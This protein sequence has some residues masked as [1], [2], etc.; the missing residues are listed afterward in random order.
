MKKQKFRFPVKLVLTAAIFL[1]L[2]IF[3]LFFLWSV[4]ASMSYFKVKDV[5]MIS[6]GR[7]TELSYL[8]GRNIWSLDLEREARSLSAANPN[9]KKVKLIRVLPNRVL[10][11][12][13]KR[14]PVAYLELS[15]YFCLDSGRVIF[16]SA[17]PLDLPVITG[18]RS[19]LVN[20]EPGV[21]YNSRELIFALNIIKAFQ[22][23]K[24]LNKFKIEKI[25]VSNTASVLFFLSEGP[26]VRMGQEETKNKMSIL[27]GFLE[28][29]KDL[30]N[31]KYIDLRFREPVVKLKDAKR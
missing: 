6:A 24:A 30:S 5:L 21:K 14:Q 3:I 18:L 23:T 22:D 19:R 31:I 1:L 15:R 25:D 29:D 28:S 27:A 16:D 13:E 7:V 11:V 2:P 17:E 12:F 26:E 9:Y 20:P 10:A 4:L 8:K